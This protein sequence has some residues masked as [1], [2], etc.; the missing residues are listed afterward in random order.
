[1]RSQGLC[2]FGN[3]ATERNRRAGLSVR[4]FRMLSRS[5]PSGCPLAWHVLLKTSE[6]YEG[7]KGMSSFKRRWDDRRA[8]LVLL[9]VVAAC[10]AWSS[11]AVA[12]EVSEPNPGDDGHTNTTIFTISRA[13]CAGNEAISF[14]L[15]SVP[16]DGSSV[17]VWGTNSGDCTLQEQRRDGTCKQIGTT[18]GYPMGGSLSLVVELTPQEV[19]SAIDNVTVCDDVGGGDGARTLKMYFLVDVAD[20]DITEAEHTTTFDMEVDLK[21]P[22]PPLDPSVGINEET[23]LL[24][25]FTANTTAQDVEGYRVYCVKLGATATGSAATGSAAGGSAA[26]GAGTGAA[27]TGGAAAAAGGAAAGGAGGAAVGGAGGA[28]VGGAGGSSVATGGSGAAGGATTTGSGGA[29]TAAAGSCSSTILIQGELP[30]TD[31]AACGDVT[32]AA[33]TQIVAAGL[34]TGTQYVLAVSATDTVGN[35]GALS[36]LVCGTPEEVTDFF[37]RYR[38]LGGAAGGGI[39]NCGLVGRRTV[40]TVPWLL[41]LGGLV[42]AAMRRRGQERR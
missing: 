4:V 8:V 10:L 23:S 41:M 17:T 9:A 39:C 20:G 2:Q 37:E 36:E 38:E 34:E 19:V 11:V 1:L 12:F 31:L 7:T 5:W 30:P 14:T 33:T 40:N 29:S 32:A 42:L 35:S 13:D 3:S 15:G 28:A 22:A 24:V 16:T 6:H 25:N 27:G 26:G 21:G 18:G